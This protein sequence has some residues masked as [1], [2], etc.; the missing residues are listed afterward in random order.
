MLVHVVTHPEVRVEPDVPVPEWGL[1][2][3]GRDH[4]VGRGAH[5]WVRLG[6]AGRT[7]PATV[8]P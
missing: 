8:S 4:L 5:P 2:E 3:A 1:S 7:G 6:P